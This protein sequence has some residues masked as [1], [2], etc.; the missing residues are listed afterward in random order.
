MSENSQI[1]TATS[2]YASA[3]LQDREDD[4]TYRTLTSMAQIA[5]ERQEISRFTVSGG[6]TTLD[7][8]IWLFCLNE[9]EPGFHF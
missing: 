9:R 5:V 1:R 3:F 4:E 8:S 6:Q 7:L 2:E